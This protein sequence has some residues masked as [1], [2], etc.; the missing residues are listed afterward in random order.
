MEASSRKRL[1]LDTNVL[2]DLA[3][4]KD[5]AH[6]F[7]E[8][9]QRKGYALLIS[10]MAVAELYFLRDHGDAEEQRLSSLSLAGL[11]TWDI[12]VFPLT[13][14]Q[15]DIARRFASA[16]I[17]QGLLPAS[18]LNDA[19][20]LA[21]AAVAEIPLVVSSDQHLLG[22]DHDA[23]RAACMEADLN[24]VFPVSPCRLTR[25]AG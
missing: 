23:L 14:L 22:V 9:Y 21:E 2:F 16:I 12:Q 4:G 17:R 8:T 7:R 25:A 6:D 24:P 1:S 10:P 3:D 20:I 5:F 19:L 11:T 15:R 18:E 13:H